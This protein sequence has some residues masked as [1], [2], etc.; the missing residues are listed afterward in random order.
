MPRNARISI[1]TLNQFVARSENLCELMADLLDANGRPVAQ[2]QAGWWVEGDLPLSSIRD[3]LAALLRP[4]NDVRAQIRLNFNDSYE[5]HWYVSEFDTSLEVHGSQLIPARAVA[6]EVRLVGRPLHD[7]ARECDDFLSY[8]P[9]LGGHRPIDIP[10]LKGEWIVYLRSADRIISEPRRIVGLPLGALPNTPLA[11]AMAIE[12]WH[13]RGK[14]LDQLCDE[15]IAEPT[16]KRSQQAIVT[17]IELA[18]SLDGLRAGTFDVLARLASHPGLGPLLLFNAAPAELDPVLQ[19]AE[20]LP[21]VWATIP[22]RH[23]FAASRAKFEQLL[24]LM[25]EQ[26]G[27]IAQVISER[28]QAIAERDDAL[29]PLL[30]LTPASLPIREIV[31]A[32]LNQSADHAQSPLPNPFRAEFD[33]ILPTWDFPEFYWRALDA[34]IIAA[35]TATERCKLTRPQL[36][37]VKDIARRHPRYFREAFAASLL[38]S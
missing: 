24:A 17:I 19:L 6:E 2:G 35:A 26:I 33:A 23:W 8:A 18:T 31:Q 13:E 11:R 20:G 3:D 22:R 10:R 1:A 29:A 21:L 14:A 9:A 5:N 16:T 28:R 4:L 38:E 25:P 15:L 34:P 36:Y 30:E 32:F 37:C 7:P 27:A 12:N